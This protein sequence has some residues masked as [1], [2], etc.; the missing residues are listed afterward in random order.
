M[1]YSP[2]LPS[3]SWK[4][5]AFILLLLCLRTKLCS[6]ERMK[7]SLC[8]KGH[9][10]N[11]RGAGVRKE[12]FPLGRTH[13]LA[14]LDSQWT[15]FPSLEACGTEKQVLESGITLPCTFQWR[16][17]KLASKTVSFTL[18]G[19]S[20]IFW[21][22]T[23]NGKTGH[24]PGFNIFPETWCSAVYAVLHRCLQLWNAEVLLVRERKFLKWIWKFK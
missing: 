9:S 11:A 8:R 1:L 23:G 17:P 16:F 14:K 10:W 20:F 2:L 4:L 21:F 12:L 13:F 7:V 24:G 5:N 15:C 18:E 6:R 19:I 3:S 22:V